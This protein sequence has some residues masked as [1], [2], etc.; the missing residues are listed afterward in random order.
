V[1]RLVDDPP[2]HRGD[3][4]GDRNVHSGQQHRAVVDALLGME[5]RTGRVERRRLDGV[6]PD[7]QRAPV[8]TDRGRQ[9]R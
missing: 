8:D 1:R 6:A 3:E 9:Q 7:Q 5:L 4:V 2:E